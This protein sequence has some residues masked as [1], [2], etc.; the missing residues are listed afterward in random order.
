MVLACT[1][2][3]LSISQSAPLPENMVL[4]FIYRVKPMLDTAS[5][6]HSANGGVRASQAR[7][8][9]GAALADDVGV[10]GAIVNEI[11]SYES[12][13]KAT[14]P[15]R[16]HERRKALRFLSTVGIFELLQKGIGG[17]VL[18]L[19]LSASAETLLGDLDGK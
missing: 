3:I 18:N 2:V 4:K 15:I 1:G 17:H 11:C 10:S 19:I 14:K 5:R 6:I 12:S 9:E 8:D 7:T 16:E 13:I